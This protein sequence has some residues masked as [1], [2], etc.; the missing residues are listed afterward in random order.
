LPNDFARDDALKDLIVRIESPERA[1][2]WLPEIRNDQVRDE[3]LISVAS[4]WLQRDRPAAETWLEKQSLSATM[5][6]RIHSAR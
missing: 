1:A 4:A 6:Q 3:T 2:E 5:L